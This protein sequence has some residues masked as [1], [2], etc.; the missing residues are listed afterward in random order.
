MLP[1]CWQQLSWDRSYFQ[2]VYNACSMPASWLLLHT[3][4]LLFLGGQGTI[5][6]TQVFPGGVTVTYLSGGWVKATGKWDFDE[7][8]KV[9]YDL[10]TITADHVEVESQN[11]IGS[12]RGHV[13]LIDPVAAVDAENLELHWAASVRTGHA[14]NA[15]IQIGSSRLRAKALDITPKLWTLTYVEGTTS[16]AHPAW[17]EVR[18]RKLTIVPGQS[19]K[20]VKPELYILG[21]KIAQ[22]PDRSFNLD[23]RSE[24]VT[25]PGFNYQ[26]QSGLGV[27]W[28]GGFLLNHN[29]DFAFGVGAFPNARPSLSA[30]ASRSFLPDANPMTIITP[31]SDLGER[32]F[33]GFMDNAAVSSPDMEDHYLNRPRSTVA[34]DTV[35]N[36]SLSDRGTSDGFSKGLEGVYET[37]GLANGYEYLGQ[38]RL[39]S[40]R[41]LGNP[42]ENRAVLVG[43]TAPKPIF[44]T[45]NLRTILRLDS[46]A[47]LGNH[48]FGWVRGFAGLAYMP[49]KQ[50]RFSAGGFY[51]TQAGTP[52]FPIDPLYSTAGYI[53][54]ADLIL[55]P[56][57]LSILR[58]YDVFWKYYDREYTISQDIGCFEPFILY[59]EYPSDYQLGLRLRLDDLTDLLT[60]RNFS[61]PAPVEHV[62]SPE[63]PGKP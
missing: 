41:D 53:G 52:D 42:F 13:H 31:S 49:V 61:R 28:G 36:Q 62:I 27:S 46:T 48:D 60:K 12:A 54:R 44:L 17:Y 23:Q 24:G 63:S 18:T 7:G 56:T 58:K 22:F 26:R 39:Q 1:L 43:S 20:M 14:E 8:V 3:A 47:Y 37:G 19:G 15:Y 51:S 11:Q 5:P 32:F 40:I 30:T 4:S 38:L 59:R 21:G 9:E 35:W 2:A 55:G 45:P 33:Y 57:K 25:I 29:T 34:V 6:Q 10:T 16:R 50:L